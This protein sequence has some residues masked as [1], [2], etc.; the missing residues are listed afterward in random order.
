MKFLIILLSFSAFSST[1]PE[2]EKYYQAQLKKVEKLKVVKKYKNGVIFHCQ[3]ESVEEICGSM[4]CTTFE[5]LMEDDPDCLKE[6][7]CFPKT[8]IKGA[9]DHFAGEYKGKPYAIQCEQ[10]ICQQ[11]LPYTHCEKKTE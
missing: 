6:S 7:I 11:N 3:G 2:Y 4:G 9:Y 10:Y 8:I 5:T 1:L